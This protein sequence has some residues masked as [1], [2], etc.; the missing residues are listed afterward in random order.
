M[1]NLNSILGAGV[2]WIF[3]IWCY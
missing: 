2:V 1:Q 3:Q